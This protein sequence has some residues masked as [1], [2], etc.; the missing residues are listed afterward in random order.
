MLIPVIVAS[1]LWIYRRNWG[2]AVKEK[3]DASVVDPFHASHRF[4]F[5]W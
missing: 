3:R 5:R 2:V 1:A 4:V